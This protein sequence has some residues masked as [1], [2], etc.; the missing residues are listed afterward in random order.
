MTTALL[1][2]PRPPLSSPARGMTADEFASFSDRPE[3]TER[4]LE[5]HAGVVVDKYASDEGEMR[6]TMLHGFMQNI[7]AFALTLYSKS[8]RSGMV[9][10][11]AGVIVSSDPDS[12]FGP[13]VAYFKDRDQLHN[14]WAE[15]PPL[16]AVEVKS[17]NETQR[18]LLR[19]VDRDLAAGVASV[20]V[21]DGDEE[22]V[23]V[24]AADRAPKVFDRDETLTCPALDGFALPL[25][26][27]FPE[28][29]TDVASPT[30]SL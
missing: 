19:K 22:F 24:Y 28:P 25:A 8:T 7:I 18:S 5:L 1:N 6:P 27:L 30:R 16:V 10:A 4:N 13:D 23:T 15:E 11:E 20:W 14:R 2:S 17:P 29:T 9:V 3:N 21:V 26:E 12:V